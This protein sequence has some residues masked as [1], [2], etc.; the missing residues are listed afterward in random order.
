MGCSLPLSCIM[1]RSV[2]WAGEPSD[3]GLGLG[4]CGE[5]GMWMFRDHLLPFARKQEDSGELQRVILSLSMPPGLQSLDYLSCGLP[6][7]LFQP[8]RL[9]VAREG[10]SQQAE[11]DLTFLFLS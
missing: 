2:A 10:F 3:S 1:V 8:K 5:V 9:H 11:D 6:L 4:I 7:R